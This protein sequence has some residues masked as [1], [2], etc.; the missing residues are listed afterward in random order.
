MQEPANP[1]EGRNYSGVRITAPP[2]RTP[3]SNY[4]PTEFGRSSTRADT[5]SEPGRSEQARILTGAALFGVIAS[6]LL[7]EFGHWIAGLLVTGQPPQFLFIA[8]RQPT[9][10]FS[11]FGGIVTWGA[12]PLLHVV[13][14]W[15][16]YLS[17]A[18]KVRRH[19]RL[20]AATGGALFFALAVTVVSWLA[21][22]FSGPASWQNDIPR[23]ATYFG[24]L[25]RIW[26][27]LLSLLTAGAIAVLAYR[28]VVAAR[29]SGR[30][31]LHVS[32][33]LI[34]AIQGGVLV[35]IATFLI[36]LAE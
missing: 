30:P 28:W 20:F 17:V 22:S 9:D 11:T 10:Q 2:T 24:S 4:P 26:M 5:N 14:L 34:G 32:P 3:E 33:A 6:V 18:G 7:H 29:S 31:G 15:I 23:V 25:G 8:V 27:H 21:A 12:G 13:A 35:L 16:A 1:A 36:S 19:P